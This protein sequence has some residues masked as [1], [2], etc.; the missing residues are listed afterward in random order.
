M[1]G[2]VELVT[3]DK[4]RAHEQVCPQRLR[5]VKAEIS[6][7]DKI[8]NPVIVDRKTKII[9]DG[10]HR[11]E[12]LKQLG[13]QLIPAMMVDY[14]SDQVRVFSRR[15]NIKISKKTVVAR[16]LKKQIFP[17]KTTKHLIKNRIRG[18]KIKLN[19]LK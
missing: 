13:C 17:Q 10:H 8:N 12:S 4:L 14:F 2:G 11:V 15:K 19:Q 16:A 18:V 6:R 1:R 7:S 9:L 3:I 5:V